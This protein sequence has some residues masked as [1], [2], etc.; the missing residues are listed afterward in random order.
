MPRRGSGSLSLKRK[1]RGTTNPAFAVARD[2]RA[3]AAEAIAAE[4]A[5]AA[6]LL[7]FPV[8]APAA[9]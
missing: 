2:E 1:K 6:E 8:P 9:E 5:E 3:A 4:L 7:G